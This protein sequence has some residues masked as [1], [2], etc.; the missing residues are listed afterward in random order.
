[1]NSSKKENCISLREL[2][3]IIGFCIV[4]FLLSFYRPLRFLKD[5]INIALDNNFQLSNFDIL[6]SFQDVGNVDFISYMYIIIPLFVTLIIYVVDTNNGLIRMIRYGDRNRI[7]NKNILLILASSFLLSILL[8]IGGYLVS[9]IILGSY[10]NLWNTETGLPY[11]LY[12]KTKIWGNLSQLLVSHKVIFIFWIMT[13]LG[14]SFIGAFI[15]TIKLFIRNIYVYIILIAIAFGDFFNIF[16]FSLIAKI[17]V[18]QRE[19][20]HPQ[21]I[22]FNIIYF[23]VGFLIFYFYGK[24]I[25]SQKDQ[26]ITKKS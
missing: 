10:K 13:F 3:I 22:T 12:G 17:S 16:N 11:L 7:W 6:S 14:L 21:S 4:I 25:N 24:Y 5:N 9:G 2:R 23:L 8:V 20:T 18:S 26:G 15:C 19:W 1:M